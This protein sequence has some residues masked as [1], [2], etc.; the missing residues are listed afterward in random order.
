VRVTDESG[1]TKDYTVTV[2]RGEKV[3]GA[4]EKAHVDRVGK[5]LLGLVDPGVSAPEGASDL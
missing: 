2:T 3:L 1:T 4:A 5:A